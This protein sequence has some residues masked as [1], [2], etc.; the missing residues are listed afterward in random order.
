MIC[1]I[2]EAEP[3]KREK[4]KKMRFILFEYSAAARVR[5]RSFD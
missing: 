5:R 2:K 4:S 3:K 1:L